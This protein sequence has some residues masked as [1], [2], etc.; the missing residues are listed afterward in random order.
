[1]LQA[2]LPDKTL[3]WMAV[4]VFEV[5][6]IRIGDRLVGGNEPCFII[7]EA[8]VNHNGE[9]DLAKKLVDAASEAG[10]DA[11]KF[12]TFVVEECTP[13]FLEKVDYQKR[14]S[15]S[16][17]SMY[18]M[19]KGLEF[20]LNDFVEIK[21]YCDEK[22]IMFISTPCD[23]KAVE[24][25]DDVGVPAFK[26]GS[27]DLT[28]L[29]LIR[30]VAKR[31]KPVIISTGMSGLSE[32]KEAV[33]VI[34][35]EGNEEV[36]ILQCTSNYPL[37]FEDV[38]LRVLETLEKNFR[39]PI[40]FSDHTPGVEASIAAVALGAKVI[41][42]HITLDKHM[43]G[44]DHSSSLEP[45]ELKNLVVCI[46]NVELA[47]GSTEK[48][49]T[50]SELEIAGKVRKSIVATKNLVEGEVLNESNIGIM[51]PGEGLKPKF[52]GQVIGKKIKWNKLAY[53]YIFWEDLE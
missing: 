37:K 20:G 52:L 14:N 13:R 45:H 49:P 12:Q 25:L 5:K 24:I 44:P 50:D 38:N 35:V 6:K 17:E 47:L 7:A 31:N 21:E 48:V 3:L 28:F 36:A 51:K 18:E 19:L 22:K 16:D 11:V 4:G 34:E 30:A 29:P 8:G 27:G 43:E 53:E 10:A 33:E 39:Y 46:R 42:K 40:G 32:I 2:T 1:M 26:I 15:G 23:F 41:E 9:I